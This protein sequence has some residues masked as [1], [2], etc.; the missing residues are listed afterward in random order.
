MLDTRKA[1]VLDIAWCVN[2]SSISILE[3]PD[4]TTIHRLDCALDVVDRQ[5]AREYF[6]QVG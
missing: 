1:S 4:L 3:D 6:V 5:R 2:G